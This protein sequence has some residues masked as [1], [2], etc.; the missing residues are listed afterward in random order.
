MRHMNTVVPTP[1]YLPRRYYLKY[2]QTLNKSTQFTIKKKVY[3]VIKNKLMQLNHLI[4]QSINQSINQIINQSIIL[5]YDYIHFLWLEDDEESRCL[6]LQDS[7]YTII[8]LN[9][10]LLL[11]SFSQHLRIIVRNCIG[12][13]FQLIFG[14]KFS[15]TT[16]LPTSVPSIPKWF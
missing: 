13:Y 9:D 12:H 7:I 14:L 15:S 10:G 5:F 2:V 1:L 4:N 11:G 8:S 6:K 16:F 3:F